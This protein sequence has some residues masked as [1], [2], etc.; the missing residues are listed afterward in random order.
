MKFHAPAV[1]PIDVSDKAEL[2]RHLNAYRDEVRLLREKLAM[3]WYE[4]ERLTSEVRLHLL[5]GRMAWL[6]EA[7]DTQE[8]P[9]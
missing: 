9:A 4:D 1:W 7:I 2:I 3:L 6:E 8:K 5:K